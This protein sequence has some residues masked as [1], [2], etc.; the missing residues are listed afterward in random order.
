MTL[1]DGTENGVGPSQFSVLTLES[2][3]LNGLFRRDTEGV[4]DLHADH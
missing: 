1:L 4:I 2:L 3:Q